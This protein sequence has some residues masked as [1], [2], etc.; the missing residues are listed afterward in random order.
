M[1]Y[2]SAVGNAE[3]PAQSCFKRESLDTDW[4]WGLPSVLL[5][6]KALVRLEK[7]SCSSDSLR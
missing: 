7:E 2:P 1:A 6:V 4:G 5:G 3:A